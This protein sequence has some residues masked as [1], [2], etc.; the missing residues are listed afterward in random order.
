MGLLKRFK[1]RPITGATRPQ[2]KPANI[3]QG[4]GGAAAE[5]QIAAPPAPFQ[6]ARGVANLRSG[7]NRATTS[8]VGDGRSRNSANVRGSAPMSQSAA[9][10]VAGYSRKPGLFGYTVHDVTQHQFDRG[11]RA[12]RVTKPNAGGPRPLYK[13]ETN[14][15]IFGPGYEEYKKRHGSL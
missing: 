9:L 4:S 5:S 7:T 6:N 14:E 1:G 3:R 2:N 13:R 10:R 15:E 11:N 12:A 8:G